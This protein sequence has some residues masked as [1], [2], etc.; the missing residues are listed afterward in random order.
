MLRS[1]AV[2]VVLALVAGCSSSRTGADLGPSSGVPVLS[3][4]PAS[5]PPAVL[6]SG[7]AAPVRPGCGTAPLNRVTE[8]SAGLTAGKGHDLS[9]A[10]MVTLNQPVAGY[11][12]LFAA[13][14]G[15]AHQPIGVWA[16]G[17]GTYDALNG[18]AQRW[19]RW[20]RTHANSA[21]ATAR[22]AALRRSIEYSTVL[23]CVHAGS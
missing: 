22:R 16:A 10:W 6:S 8:V 14:I 7:P 9:D 12:D 13:K 2:L 23:L 17:D 19:S 20:G 18:P 21:G 4:A 15:V 5:S 11:T 3:G 1:V